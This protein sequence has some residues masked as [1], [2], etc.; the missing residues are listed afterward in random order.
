MKDYSWLIALSIV[1][2]PW[3]MVYGL[4]ALKVSRKSDDRLSLNK[5]K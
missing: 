4:I 2:S 1:H 3:S 5:A